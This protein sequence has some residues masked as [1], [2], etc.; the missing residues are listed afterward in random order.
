MKKTLSSLIL[1]AGF[2]ANAQATVFTSLD[3]PVSILDISTVTSTLTV[4][5]HFSI[6]DLN[7]TLNIN[8]TFDADL[9][10]FL[11]HGSTTVELTS[12]NGG[13]GDN[14]INTTFDDEAATAITAGAA[15]FAGSFRPEALLSLFDGSDAFG[16]W[17]L[18][19]TDDLGADVGTLNSWSLDI[20]GNNVPEPATI[21]LLGLGLL[22]LAT[23]RRRKTA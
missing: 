21:G 5:S 13:G 14:F 12:D 17:T 10:I 11:T 15:P 7:L 4:G 1:A 22:G 6:T 16:T 8:H 9:D 2:A 23:S 20:T 18:S 19:I 3:V